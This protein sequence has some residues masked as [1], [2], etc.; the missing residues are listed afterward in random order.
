MMKVLRLLFLLV[1]FLQTVTCSWAVFATSSGVPTTASS[2]TLRTY[3]D[4][5]FPFAISD[6]EPVAHKADSMEAP[7]ELTDNETWDSAWD[8]GLRESLHFNLAVEGNKTAP[9]RSEQWYDFFRQY[10]IPPP[11]AL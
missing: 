7:R 9:T 11:E 1:L 5:V 4:P 3:T 8:E 6:F 10:C 2:I